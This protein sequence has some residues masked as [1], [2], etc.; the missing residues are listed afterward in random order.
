M[1]F[2]SNVELKDQNTF[3]ISAKARK[4]VELTT[5]DEAVSLFRE[6]YSEDEKVLILGGGSNILL[7]SDFEGLVI[8]NRIK[9]ISI[10]A[11]NEQYIELKVGAG[12]NW[13]EFVLYCVNNGYAGIE[14][15]SLIPGNVG[16]SP[17]QNIGAYGVEVKEVITE[18]EAID[19]ANGSIHYFTNED[20]QF[21]YR[22]SIFKTELRNKFFITDVRF[23]LNKTPVFKTE[24]G[25]I[26]DQLKA[27]NVSPSDL[28]IKAISDAVIAIRQSKLPDPNQL[29]NSGSFFKNPIVNQSTFNSLK[30][31]F[32]AMPSYPLD[33]GDYKLAAGW[34]IEQA[35]WKGF[36]EGDY[37]VH[38]K[39]ALVLVNYG[40]ASGKEIQSLSERIVSS[41]K[42]QF[43][44][45]LER[46]VNII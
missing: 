24:Y 35:G 38:A 36:R 10:I 18:V 14:N 2:L 29:G 25:A 26:R 9:G 4:F 13:H 43:G 15:L 44:I 32:D 41:I 46:E 20:C 45:E 16:A 27:N 11:E 22:S 39:Q 28:S 42:D 37:G 7:T 3:G 12:E 21:D 6:N 30:K 34:L 33:N 5:T 19:R 40:K 31:R 23:R 1:K 8:K 17:M